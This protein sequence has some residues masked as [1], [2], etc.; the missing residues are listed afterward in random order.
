MK[1][2]INNQEVIPQVKPTLAETKDETLDSFSFVLVCNKENP[3]A[4]LQKVRLELQDDAN[5]ILHFILSVD[6]VDLYSLNPLSYRHSITLTQNTRELNKHI[7]KNTVFSQPASKYKKSYFSNSEG[8]QEAI[9]IGSHPDIRAVSDIGLIPKLNPMTGQA[10][11]SKPLIL[12]PKEKISKAF[13]KITTQVAIAQATQETSAEWLQDI[14]TLDDINNAITGKATSYSDLKLASLHLKYELSGQTITETITPYSFGG[15]VYFD[16]LM[17]CP[18][19]KELADMGANNFELTTI[20]TRYYDNVNDRY[21]YRYAPIFFSSGGFEPEIGTTPAFIMAQIEIVAETY[22]HS[23]YDILDLLIKRQK[24]K[25]LYYAKSNLF[26]LPQSGELYNLLTNTVAPNFTFTQSTMYECVAD[27]FRLFDAIFTMD[28]N[29]ELGIEYFNDRNQRYDSLTLIGKNQAIAEDKY[30]NGIVTHYQDARTIFSFPSKKTYAPLR[31]AELG[32]PDQSDHPFIVPHPI[33]SVINGKVLSTRVTVYNGYPGGGAS[34]QVVVEGNLDLDVTH[35]IV[36]DELAT[37]L[38]IT[39]A[40]PDDPSQ[41]VQKNALTFQKGGTILQTGFIYKSWYGT[42]IVSFW[43]TL[44]CA[45]YRMMGNNNVNM[46][47]PFNPK[48]NYPSSQ[49]WASVRMNLTYI[50]TTDGRVKVESLENRYDGDTLID[51]SNGAVDLN[52]LGL[53]MLGVISKIGQPSFEANIKLTSWENRIKKGDYYKRN[54]EYWIANVC[55]FT[56][57]NDNTIS[58]KITFIKNFNSLALTTRLLREKRMSNISQELIQ[59]SEDNYIEYCYFSSKPLS[60]SLGERTI[61]GQPTNI[62]RSTLRTFKY[63]G[64]DSNKVNYALVSQ[65]YQ[66]VRLA[67]TINMGDGVIVPD[68]DEFE[69]SIIISV[70]GLND[71]S[72]KNVEYDVNATVSYGTIRYT[73]NNNNTITIYVTARN[74]IDFNLINVSISVIGTNLIY[75]PLIK[76]GSGNALCFEMSFREPISAG[77]RTSVKSGWFGSN[78]YFTE[79]VYYSD[80]YGFVDKQNIYFVN[81]T[82]NIADNNFPIVTLTQDDTIIGQLVDYEFYK[83]PNEILALNYE[84]LFLPIDLNQDFIGSE[85]INNHYLVVDESKIDTLYLYYTTT[86]NTFEYSFLDTEGEGTR[87]EIT[88]VTL[89]NNILEFTFASISNVKTW[90]ICNSKGKILFA[91]NNDEDAEN[92]IT[93]KKI[94]L[95][96]RHNRIN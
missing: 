96:T 80:E 65:E 6:S 61:F 37:L 47:E 86:D 14:H 30:V 85:F 93:T 63:D 44:K 95:L 71:K 42:S 57:L 12:T 8:L 9:Q 35:Y 20:W 4:P 38:D 51:Q 33:S 59:K 3:F 17:E 62:F 94:Y 39:N 5:T 91:S 36:N 45:F 34:T 46:G 73:I 70:P 13:V 22:Y 68:G 89:T 77:N 48:I 31:S 7:V 40:L 29:G 10:D 60:L 69:S 15:T 72:Y 41:L 78:K 54:N 24:Q 76:Y 67:T 92:T 2:Y 32:V 18:R 66:S 19:I 43:N 50:A 81:G 55:N 79:A 27:V 58:E 84:L 53:N 74:E 26:S 1:V 52:K 90:A 83:Q 88:N 64:N 25:N 87:T 23:C 82:K 28:G 11:S 75:F 21:F 49:D 16:R 56:F